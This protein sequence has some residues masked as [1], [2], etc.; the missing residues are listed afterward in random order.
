[1]TG[2]NPRNSVATLAGRT[3]AAATR[4]SRRGGGTS[5]PG[6][7]ARRISP[8]ILGDIT[9]RLTQGVVMVSG[10]NGKTTTSRLLSSVLTAQGIHLLHNRSGSNL[11]SGITSSVISSTLLSG[12]PAADLALFETDEA[13]LPHVL[14]EVTPRVLVLNN[15]FRDQLDRYGELDTLY[16]SWE[17][18]VTALPPETRL[19]VNG[20]DPALARIAESAKC[21]VHF[22]GLDDPSNAIHELP[23]AA[24]AAICTRCKSPLTYS[25]VYVSHMGDY[26]CPNCGLARPRLDTRATRIQLNGLDSTTFHIEGEFGDRQINLK[27]PGIYNVYNALAA[28]VAALALGAPWE[29]IES[30]F[31]SFSAAFGRFERVGARDRQIVLALVKNPVGCNEVLRMVASQREDA[32]LLIIINDNIADGRD[33]SWLWDA[34]F[35]MISALPG[36]FITSGLRAEDMAVRLKY[37]GIP[38]D[39]ITIEPNIPEA[40]DKAIELTP[41]DHTLRV[42]PTYTSM[43]ELRAHMSRLGWVTPYWE[44]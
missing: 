43:L 22:Y 29:A 2:F 10:T 20:D 1:M 44:E 16:R 23:H 8:G 11:M 7:V 15:L 34:D 26:K 42:L 27:I 40:L 37:A 32:P 41:K 30:G 5:L 33:V 28:I 3:V 17:R 9:V 38:S 35:E 12:R 25:A 24:D 31:N 18:S 13:V 39:H 36:P 14:E 21:D 6:I 19:I 4:L